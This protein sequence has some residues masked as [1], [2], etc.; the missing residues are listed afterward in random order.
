M[1]IH[2]WSD[3]SKICFEGSMSF[4]LWACMHWCGVYY[5]SCDLQNLDITRN[6]KFALQQL[7][8]SPQKEVCNGF[9][10]Y[11]HTVYQYRGRIW[12]NL[13]IADTLL[14]WTPEPSPT[15]VHNREVVRYTGRREQAH[16]N[17]SKFVIL[18]Y[19]FPWFQGDTGISLLYMKCYAICDL[20]Q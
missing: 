5:F 18:I 7:W 10:K 14:L 17:K 16:C 6:L 15:H 8:W 1:W 13:P 9:N 4:M 20:C 2:G 19:L 3:F 11:E 12:H